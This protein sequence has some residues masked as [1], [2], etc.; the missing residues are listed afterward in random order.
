MGRLSIPLMLHH[1]RC[2]LSSLAA[3]KSGTVLHSHV[4]NEAVICRTAL[5]HQVSRD[6][7]PA[8]RAS[9][10]DGGTSWP[11]DWLPEHRREYLRRAASHHYCLFGCTRPRY[12]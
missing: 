10:C 4:P 6:F 3:A 2:I 1:P 5:C 11:P 12:L 8:T 7:C 9:D